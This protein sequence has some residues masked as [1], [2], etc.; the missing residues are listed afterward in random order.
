MKDSTNGRKWMTVL[1]LGILSTLHFSASGQEKRPNLLYV[2][3]DQFRAQ[4]EGFMHQDPVQTPN[5]DKLAHQGVVF[6]NAVSNRP[7]CSPYRGMLMTGQYC[8]ADGIQTNCNTSSRRYSNFLREDATTISD[9]LNANGYYCGYIGKWHL[10]APKGP[11]VDD[12]QKSVWEAYTP[13]GK[14]RHGFKFWYSYGCSDRHLHPHYWV[15]NAPVQD[16]LFVN[17]WSPIH[18]AGVAIDFIKKQKN[19]KR[20]WALFVAMN[21]PHPP[22]NEVPEKYKK[23]YA[24]IPIDSLLNRPNVPEGK[25][26]DRGRKWVR[27][28]FAAVSG[29]DDQL[30]RILKVLKKTGQDKNTI[31][32]F[33]SDHGE[34]MGSHGLMQ[35]VWWYDEAFRIPFIVRW[36]AK[37]QPGKNNLNLSV[38]DIMPTLLDL[39]GM[40]EKI[41]SSVQGTD[42]ANVFLGDTIGKPEFALYINSRFDSGL[43]GYRGLRN[44]KYTFVVQRDNAGTISH[45]FLYDNQA[46]PYQLHNIAGQRADLVRDLRQKLMNR[47][48]KIR[49]PWIIYSNKYKIY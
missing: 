16:T 28:Y 36:P 24:N 43:G 12:Y 27:D 48:E 17:E 26:G 35:K 2:F 6:T 34:L 3:P 41:P 45:L 47:L 38:P 31:V 13:P 29:V 8:F 11:D 39:M 33:S 30:G 25:R 7:L 22:Y 20:P 44:G 1:G 18:E 10:D 4:A 15:N 21:P 19:K 49:D 32:I 14:K 42:Y 40:K 37:L 9:V 23:L 5:I 46:D